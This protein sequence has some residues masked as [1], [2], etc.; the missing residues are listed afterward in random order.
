MDEISRTVAVFTPPWRLRVFVVIF[1]HLT[2]VT[3][4]NDGVGRVKL[5]ILKCHLFYNV[6]ENLTATID[7]KHQDLIH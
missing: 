3:I 6:F 2:D 7:H 4:K 5:F 1:R